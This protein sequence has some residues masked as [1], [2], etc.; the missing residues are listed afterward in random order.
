MKH[1]QNCNTGAETQVLLREQINMGQG[2]P[3][4]PHFKASAHTVSTEEA[5]NAACGHTTQEGNR[6]AGS[7]ST[8]SGPL[9]PSLH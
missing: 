4:H 7:T 2:T 1:C 8:H 3:D 9:G 5:A 6:P